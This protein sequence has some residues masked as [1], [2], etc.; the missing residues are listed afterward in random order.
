MGGRGGDRG[1]GKT[2]AGEESGS[3]KHLFSGAASS[4]GWVMCVFKGRQPRELV[5]A[6]GRVKSG[7]QLPS[8]LTGEQFGR[9]KK[10]LA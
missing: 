6:K 5:S 3:F 2:P 9:G 1:A 4:P 8:A 7:V 10:N